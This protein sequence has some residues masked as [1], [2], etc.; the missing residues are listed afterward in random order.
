MDRDRSHRRKLRS[1]VLGGVVGAGAAVAAVRRDRRR[2]R[3][4]GG[5]GLGAFEGAPCYREAVEAAPRRDT[6]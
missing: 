2:H 5:T 3:P 4:G 6:A 1:F